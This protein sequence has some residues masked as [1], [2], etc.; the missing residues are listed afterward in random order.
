MQVKNSKTVKDSVLKDDVHYLTLQ[1]CAD[2]LRVHYMTLYKWIQ[3]GEGPPI[4]HF[5]KRSIRIP[6][7][8]FLSW[9]SNKEAA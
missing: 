6:K 9:A 4:K 8:A 3:K 5:G 1:E 7:A 2:Y